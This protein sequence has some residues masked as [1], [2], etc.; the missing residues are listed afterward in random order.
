MSAELRLALARRILVLDGAA[1]TALLQPV[2]WGPPSGGPKTPD[3]SALHRAYLAAGADII[4]THTFSATSYEQHR[5][6]AQCARRAADAAASAASDRPRFVAGAMGPPGGTTVATISDL[7][8]ERM[9]GLL[10]EGVDALLVETIV[11]TRHARAAV[12]A[13]EGEQQARGR[14]L[15]LMLS[16]AVT[17]EGRLLS[18]ETLEAFHAAIQHAAPL[19]VGINCGSGAGHLRQP[20]ERLSSL[21]G[22]FV[23]CHPSA[24]L[25]DAFGQYDEAPADTAQ[26]LREFAEAGLLNIAGGCCGTTPEHIQA[27]AAAVRDVPARMT[28]FKRVTWST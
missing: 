10:D 28:A 15:A 9:Q 6:A 1:A 8:R 4:T 3:V 11:D 17:D 12:E 26:R 23:S 14:A 21:S 5:A 2:S 18:G 19:C 7:Y 27:I 22:T 20:L 16:V 24:G 13:V 25:P